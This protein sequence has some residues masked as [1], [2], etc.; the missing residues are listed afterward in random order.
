M[1]LKTTTEADGTL[2]VRTPE[3]LNEQLIQKLRR[4]GFVCW[5]WGVWKKKVENGDLQTETIEVESDTQVEEK[6]DV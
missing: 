5:G 1:N 3:V 6:N 4:L 2:V